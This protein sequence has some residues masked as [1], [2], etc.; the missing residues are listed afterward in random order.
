M[1]VVLMT[2]ALWGTAALAQ[3]QPPP[4]PANVPP[5]APAVAGAPAQGAP[6]AQ[7]SVDRDCAGTLFCVTGQ[8]VAQNPNRNPND[9]SVTATKPPEEK[10]TNFGIILDVGI[11]DGGALGIL[12]RPASFLRISG[13]ATYNAVG[14]GARGGITLVPFH[15]AITPTVTVEGGHYFAADA[16]PLVRQ[17]FNDPTITSPALQAVA[18]DYVN[19]HLGL[20]IGS[21]QHFMFFLRGGGS[22]IQSTIKNSGQVLQQLGGTGGTPD[23]TLEVGDLKITLTVPSVKLGIIAF[24]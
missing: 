4:Q 17:A 10:L 11:P 15:F 7:C 5:P 19:A 23:P 22:Y 14:F 9:V 20:E 1:R 2:A 8:C 24:F 16:T 18:Y 13:A 3:T 21:P 12:Y 6:R